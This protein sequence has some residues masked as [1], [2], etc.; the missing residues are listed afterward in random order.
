MTTPMLARSLYQSRRL[1]L[2]LTVAVI[3][4]LSPGGLH[5]A[6]TPVSAEDFATRYDDARAAFEKQDYTRTQYLAEALLKDSLAQGKISPQL[7]QLLGHTRYRQGDLGRAALWYMRAS[8]FPPPSAETAQNLSHIHGKTGNLAFST[9]KVT[10]QFAAWL[11]RSQ[12]MRLVFISAWTLVFSLVLYFLVRFPGSRTTCFSLALIALVAGGLSLTGWFLRPTYEDVRH[13][14]V[15]TAADTQSYTSATTTGG[16]VI[17]LPLGSQVRKLEERGAWSYVETWR[18]ESSDNG[19]MYRG[20]VQN[21]A[22]S[23]YWPFDAS[24]L[25]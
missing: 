18:A 20:W 23:A 2:A 3:S 21:S 17:A 12:W 7:F 15:V 24:F 10:D 8:L 25:E 4:F 13:L 19:Q 9:Q 11:T 14:A 16:K 22:L 5:A 1:F 6:P